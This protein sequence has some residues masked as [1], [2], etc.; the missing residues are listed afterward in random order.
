MPVDN[1]LHIV[2]IL[3]V[4]LSST[5]AASAAVF[6][7]AKNHVAKAAIIGPVMNI[8][9]SFILIFLK[10]TLRPWMAKGQKNLIGQLPDQVFIFL[11]HDS[12][13]HHNP[14]NTDASN[15]FSVCEVDTKH[16]LNMP[17]RNN[18]RWSNFTAHCGSC[19]KRLTQ[20]SIVQSAQ[21]DSCRCF[22]IYERLS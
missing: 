22:T 7:I 18:C 4:L 2:I 17:R 16:S 13:K 5:E 9:V 21:I 6:R 8:K 10:L 11:I 19:N 1:S 14:V 3:A 12:R 15:P 20:V